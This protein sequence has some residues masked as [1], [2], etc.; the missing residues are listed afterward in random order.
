[1]LL[2]GDLAVAEP[3]KLPYQLLHAAARRHG[4]Q[5]PH[6]W[7]RGRSRPRCRHPVSGRQHGR[8]PLRR[9]R[10]CRRV[11]PR[12]PRHRRHRRRAGR[13]RLPADAGSPSPK[14]P[15]C[16]CTTDHVARLWRSDQA[17]RAASRSEARARRAR[18]AE[19]D[20]RRIRRFVPRRRGQGR[21]APCFRSRILAA[22]KAFHDW[23]RGPQPIRAWMVGA[24]PASMCAHI[25]DSARRSFPPRIASVISWCSCTWVW[26]SR[27]AVR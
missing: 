17:A 6:D 5:V 14:E 2:D 8:D 12:L 9:R 25:R 24:R 19:P 20:R 11:P 16:A 27:V 26:T 21:R 15:Q 23:R 10:G 4:L 1:M 13:V 7:A 18:R 22:A 3:K